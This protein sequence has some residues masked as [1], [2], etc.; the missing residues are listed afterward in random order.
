MLLTLAGLFSSCTDNTTFPPEEVTPPEG[1]PPSDIISLPYEISFSDAVSF[2]M[3]EE[4]NEPEGIVAYKRCT[5]DGQPLAKLQFPQGEAYL[6]KDSIP[7]GMDAKLKTSW[8]MLFESEAD[9]VFFI[10]AESELGLPVTCMICNFPAFAK[11]WDIPEGGCK[12]S[13]EGIAYGASF[14]GTTDRIL[15]DYVLVNVKRM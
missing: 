4:D 6:F 10:L 9:R 1:V 13:F 5:A 14:G 8:L 11:A 3:H 2:P 12:V 7:T 15:M